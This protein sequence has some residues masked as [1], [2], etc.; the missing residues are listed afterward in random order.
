MA[1]DRGAHIGRSEMTASVTSLLEERADQ[2]FA[3]LKAAHG[4]SCRNPVTGATFVWGIDS[5]AVQ[6]KEAMAALSA[7]HWFAV[8]RP[9][10]ALHLPLSD[11]DL[12]AYRNARGLA[13]LVGFFARSLS[14]EGFGRQAYDFENHPSFYDFA[15][16]LMAINTGMWGIEKDARLVLRFPPRRL[17]DMTPGAYWAPPKEHAETMASYRRAGIAAKPKVTLRKRASSGSHF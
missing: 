2:L 10:D 12:E 13:A 15:C 7:L 16:G 9:P 5:V 6:K 17:A 1:D 8:N 4:T 3:G 14:R 11:A